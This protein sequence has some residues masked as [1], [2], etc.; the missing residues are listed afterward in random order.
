MNRDKVV[1]AALLAGSIAVIIIYV[2]LVW[3]P[4]WQGLDTIILKLTGTVAVAA[5]FGIL[6]WIGYTLATT[7]P[8]KPI[9]EIEKEIEEELKKLEKEVEE[10]ES[11]EEKSEGAGS[12]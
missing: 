2:W 5:V 8:P 4:L 3:L 10:E 6:A 7:P 11:S 9:E 12:G 1:G